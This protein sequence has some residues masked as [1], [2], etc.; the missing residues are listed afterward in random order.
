M[1]DHDTSISQAR[2]TLA[3]P[4]LSEG[5]RAEALDILANGL[6][7][8]AKDS[9][10]ADGDRAR[11]DVEE[12]VY[13][14]RLAAHLQPQCVKSLGALANALFWRYGNATGKR[15]DLDEAVFLGRK[16]VELAVATSHPDMPALCYDLALF[17]GARYVQDGA[18]DDANECVKLYNQAL[19]VTPSVPPDPRWHAFLRALGQSVLARYKTKSDQDDQLQDQ[20]VSIRKAVVELLPLTHDAL[21]ECLFELGHALH[22]RFQH[23]PRGSSNADD[24]DECIA[25]YR[26]S[27]D[28][29]PMLHVDLATRL[30]ILAELLQTRFMKTQKMKDIE[31]S[32]MLCKRA[33][34][35]R[36]AGH[37]DRADSMRNLG[38]AFRLLFKSGC[39]KAGVD[40]LHTAIL[41]KRLYVAMR[42]P[43][44]PGRSAAMVE[45][46]KCLDIRFHLTKEKCDFTEA[47]VL[48]RQAVTLTS[49]VH[50]KWADLLKNFAFTLLDRFEDNGF[51][52]EKDVEQAIVIAREALRIR[53]ESES[54]YEL[55]EF[56]NQL[57]YALLVRMQHTHTGLDAL[58]ECIALHRRALQLRPEPHI[59]RVGSLYNLAASLFIRFKNGGNIDDLHE[60]ISL[61]RP[62]LRDEVHK[63]EFI[64]TFEEL[65]DALEARFAIDNVLYKDDIREAADLRKRV[66]RFDNDRSELMDERRAQA[67]RL[68]AEE[69]IVQERRELQQAYRDNALLNHVCTPIL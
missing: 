50:P 60:A 58:E 66:E 10:G 28:L 45:L 23:P 13:H 48:Y 19:E 41:L 34:E 2:K 1:E 40:Y 20:L 52:E 67:A 16:A 39:P 57:G 17:L 27:L 8:R 4:S 49:P 11:N 6:L 3:N 47:V 26:R 44:H 35:V 62:A 7:A 12:A 55:S 29:Q 9:V 42:P 37:A 53:V 24:L 68:A 59:E 54:S 21:P 22:I 33:V 64:G 56:L 31:D 61:F 46:A 65:A 30:D 18:K 51:T 15:S 5:E 38:E 69:K 63:V 14:L 36:P 25:C 32:M 43:S